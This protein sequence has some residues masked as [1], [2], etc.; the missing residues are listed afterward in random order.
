MS[1]ADVVHGVEDCNRVFFR[2]FKETE[3]LTIMGFPADLVLTL[4]AN[5]T[6]KASGNA[7]PPPLIVAGLQPMLM[8]LARSGVDLASWPPACIVAVLPD[9]VLLQVRRA[10]AARS[11]IVDKARYAKAKARGKKRPI[12]D[13][14]SS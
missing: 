2:R 7:Y 4:G 9:A 13:S 8:T 14:D 5:L 3:R 11:R 6:W 12:D 1:V 10:L